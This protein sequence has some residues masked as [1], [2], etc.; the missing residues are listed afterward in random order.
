MPK[1]R[2]GW[3]QLW[4]VDHLTSTGALFSINEFDVGSVAGNDWLVGDVIGLIW[5]CSRLDSESWTGELQCRMRSGSCVH[6]CPGE[7]NTIFHLRKDRPWAL[8]L[9]AFI[10]CLSL[11]ILIYLTLYLSCSVKLNN[12]ESDGWIYYRIKLSDCIMRILLILV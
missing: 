6:L 5:H 1:N 11:V 10:H 7:Q 8:A 2:C 12:N 4:G 3:E 9:I